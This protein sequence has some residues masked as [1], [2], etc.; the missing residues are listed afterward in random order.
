LKTTKEGGEKKKGEGKKG[1]RGLTAA[2]LFSCFP[3]KKN[4]S[5]KGQRQEE[6]GKKRVVELLTQ[7]DEE[8]PPNRGRSKE[9]EKKERKQGR[10]YSGHLSERT[11]GADRRTGEGLKKEKKEKKRKRGEKK[12]VGGKKAGC[13][14][15]LYLSLHSQLFSSERGRHKVKKGEQGGRKKK[16]EEREGKEGSSQHLFKSL[17]FMGKRGGNARIDP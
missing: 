7:F 14:H 11:R 17:P 16:E 8:R 4:F 3:R 13:Q 12:R 15:L 2:G 6:K 1:R 10:H 9:G 5:F